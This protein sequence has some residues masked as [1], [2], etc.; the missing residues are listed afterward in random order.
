MSN[1]TSASCMMQTSAAMMSLAALACWHPCKSQVA[2]K[3]ASR[4]DIDAEVQVM[5]C[6][7]FLDA[8]Q[9]RLVCF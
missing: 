3:A 9:E 7:K 6:Q 4:S 1:D 2:L 8:G 5:V